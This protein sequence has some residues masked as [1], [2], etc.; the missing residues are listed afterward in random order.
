MRIMETWTTVPPGPWRAPSET[1]DKELGWEFQEPRPSQRKSRTMPRNFQT[2][3]LSAPVTQNQPSSPINQNRGTLTPAGQNRMAIEPVNPQPQSEFGIGATFLSGYSSNVAQFEGAPAASFFDLNANM[4]GYY[5]VGSIL[6]LEFQGGAFYRG[7]QNPEIN[8]Q[9]QTLFIDGEASA[10]F[11]ISESYYA[12]VTGGRSQFD[13]RQLD[14]RS[15]TERGIDSR[16]S[17]N[18]ALITV[19]RNWMESSLELF[20][21]QELLDAQTPAIDEFGNEFLT[22]FTQNQVGG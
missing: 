14:F 11:L 3:G 2:P 5:P 8:D 19:G 22:D 6:D 9:F 10:K 20:I 18:R 21:G 12:K 4:N 17:I 13:G 1:S 15:N 7:F 16:F